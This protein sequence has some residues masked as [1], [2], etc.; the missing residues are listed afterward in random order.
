VLNVRLGTDTPAHPVNIKFGDY[1]V[2][3][4]E[5]R[6]GRSTTTSRFLSPVVQTRVRNNFTFVLEGAESTTA[7]VKTEWNILGDEPGQCLEID[8]GIDVDIEYCSSGEV[9]LDLPARGYEFWDAGRAIGCA[10]EAPAGVRDDGNH[11]V[12]GGG[13]VR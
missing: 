11:G 5:L 13:P 6:E 9:P 2:V 10:D 4:S 8:L 1:A 12:Q 3:S 7:K